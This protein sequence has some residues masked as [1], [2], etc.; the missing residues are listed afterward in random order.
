LLSTKPLIQQWEFD[1]ES[2]ASRKTGE[3]RK[4]LL[5][6]REGDNLNIE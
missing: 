5:K 2:S 3:A 6:A 1:E 4:A